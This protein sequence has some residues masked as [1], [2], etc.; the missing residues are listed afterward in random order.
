M[1]EGESRALR[2]D[3][4]E[5]FRGAIAA[6]DPQ[7]L[8]ARVL[9]R[10]HQHAE[11]ALPGG[12]VAQYQLPLLVVGAGKAAARMA[13]ACEAALGADRVSGGVVV[14]QGVGLELDSIT[15][16][17]AGHPLPDRRGVAA[18]QHLM[19][20]LETSPA[21]SVLCLISGGASSLLVAPRAPLTLADKVQTTQLLLDCGA[22]ISE[23]NSLRK[24]LSEVKGGGLL[25]RSARPMMSL[26]ISDVVGDDPSTIGS[27]PALPDPTTFA[28]A[29]RVLERYHLGEAVPHSVSTLLRRGLAGLEPE[30]VKPGSPEAANKRHAVIGSNRVALAGAAATAR[31]LGWSIHLTA[32]PIVGDTTVAARAFAAQLLE[33]AGKDAPAC[34]LAG[35]ET[36]VQV[37]G[38]GRGGRNQEF[39][40]AA[41]AQ[42][43][44]HD[45]LLL[46]AGTDGIDGPTDAA[47]AY[48]D[49]TTLT[50]AGARGLDP[51]AA[52]ADNDS[53]PFFEALG[54]LFRC[55]PSGTN[56]MDIKIALVGRRPLVPN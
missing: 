41:A 54:D 50:R 29:W 10:S 17:E 30:T 38:S 49:G 42:L 46:S 14:N 11:V 13:A 32:E 21:A 2:A 51:A 24:H 5:I 15:V 12:L 7:R 47:G 27:G 40:L 16:L 23:I 35:G 26:L 18:A 6:V 8:V 19:R 20:L 28:E 33:L 56:V 1:S 25:R 31:A 36:T 4:T 9:C 39:A 45:V 34:L 55:G 22:E 48:A 53:Y 3:A 44:G 37:R 43:S 52:L